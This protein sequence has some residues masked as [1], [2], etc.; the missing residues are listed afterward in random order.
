MS[1]GLICF[2]TIPK[3]THS[4]SISPCV[5]ATLNTVF[6]SWAARSSQVRSLGLHDGT[7]NITLD[8]GHGMILSYNEKNS[9]Y[10]G[11]RLSCNLNLSP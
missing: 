9:P 8:L 10:T 2:Y 3:I 1:E 11:H 6:A 4:I 5:S 7:I